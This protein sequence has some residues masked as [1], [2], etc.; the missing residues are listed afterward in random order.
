MYSLG[1]CQIK[2]V[3][4]E[5]VVTDDSPDFLQ[6]PRVRA[7]LDDFT[8]LEDWESRYAH[9]IALGKNLQPLEHEERCQANK[10]QGLCK[11]GLAC[12]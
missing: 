4:K 11:P 9:V 6:D 8:W 12:Y 5:T 7:V 2:H 3:R 1:L 10:V